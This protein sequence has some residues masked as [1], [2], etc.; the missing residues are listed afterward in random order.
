MPIA[1]RTLKVLFVLGLIYCGGILV[2][3]GSGVN[4]DEMMQGRIGAT[5]VISTGSFLEEL[6][7][8]VRLSHFDLAVGVL[9]LSIAAL[10]ALYR[11]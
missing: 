3:S 9:M 2:L 7:R 10:L 1:A 11:A 5:A 8:V 6:L 4:L